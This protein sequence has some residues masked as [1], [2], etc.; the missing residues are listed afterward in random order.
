MNRFAAMVMA[1]LGAV[2]SAQAQTGFPIRDATGRPPAVAQPVPPPA[3]PV[4]RPDRPRPGYPPRWYPPVTVIYGAVPDQFIPWPFQFNLPN[5][6]YGTVWIR[7]N[8]DAVLFDRIN[9]TI[10]QV[11][12]RWFG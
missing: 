10:L 2:S 11:R 3:V 5:P 9:R 12:S 6:P 4:P 1:V 8:N 7:S